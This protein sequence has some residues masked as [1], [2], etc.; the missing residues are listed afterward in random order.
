MSTDGLEP[1]A[2]DVYPISEGRYLIGWYAGCS[3]GWT[4]EERQAA[5]R[6]RA[7]ADL[8]DHFRTLRP[9]AKD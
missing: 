9:H 4:G 1:H 8:L 5:H 3:C 2:A 7:T 6:G